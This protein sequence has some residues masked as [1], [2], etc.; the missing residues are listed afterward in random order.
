M[1]RLPPPGA[2]VVGAK[3]PDYNEWIDDDYCG[4]CGASGTGMCRGAGLGP[5]TMS[6]SDNRGPRRQDHHLSVITT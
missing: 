3:R 5:G 1:P 2:G 6:R 4:G